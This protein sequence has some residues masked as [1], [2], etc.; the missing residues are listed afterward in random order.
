MLTDRLELMVLYE[1]IIFNI[2]R[3]IK[4]TDL[5]LIIAKILRRMINFQQTSTILLQEL[6]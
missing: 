3:F 2:Y 1:S 4:L 6:I 5:Q